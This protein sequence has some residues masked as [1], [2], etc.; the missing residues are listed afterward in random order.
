MYESC[1]NVWVK[2]SYFPEISGKSGD[3]YNF[4]LETDATSDDIGLR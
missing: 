2:L 1:K 3:W 4:D